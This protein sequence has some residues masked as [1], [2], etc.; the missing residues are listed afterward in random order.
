VQRSRTAP[1]L[2]RKGALLLA[3]STFTTGTIL[4]GVATSMEMLIVARTIA[5]IGGGG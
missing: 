5:G 4:C 3:V 1:V 2:G